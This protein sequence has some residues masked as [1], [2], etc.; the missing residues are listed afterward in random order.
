MN[1]LCWKGAGD[2]AG[3]T[4]KPRGEYSPVCNVTRADRSHTCSGLAED[5]SADQR[6]S[7][8]LGVIFRATGLIEPIHS[9][10]Y[11]ARDQARHPPTRPAACPAGAQRACL[12]PNMLKLISSYPG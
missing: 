8:M 10:F 1:V 7:L 5:P 6:A 12:G 9:V 3:T 2:L 4:G 11:S